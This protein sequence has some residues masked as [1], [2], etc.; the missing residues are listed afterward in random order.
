[1]HKNANKIYVPPRMGR[2]VSLIVEGSLMVAN[3]VNTLSIDNDGQVK[4]GWYDFSGG[5]GSY[6]E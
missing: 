5:T 4:D 1:M 6:W 2:A 3:S